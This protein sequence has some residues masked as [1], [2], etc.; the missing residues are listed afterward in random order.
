[1]TTWR[2]SKPSCCSALPCA[3][4]GVL[5]G[6]HSFSYTDGRPQLQ[7]VTADHEVY[8]NSCPFAIDPGGYAD[9]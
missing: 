4:A 6:P 9:E 5:R 3:T 7:E 1:M 8:V 2:C